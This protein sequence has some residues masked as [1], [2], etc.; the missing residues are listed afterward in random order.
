MVG[1]REPSRLGY[2]PSW[3]GLAFE[4]GVRMATRA[5]RTGRWLIAVALVAAAGGF[6]A[7]AQFRGDSNDPWEVEVVAEFPH[8]PAAFTQG[9][10]ISGG[11]LYESTGRYGASSIRRVDIETGQIERLGALNARLFGEGLTIRGDRA[12]QLTW[13]SG[14]GIVYDVDTFEILETFRYAGEGWGLTH[15]GTH[16]ILSDGTAVLRFI[17]PENYEQAKRLTVR[18]GDLE[19]TRLNEL[20]YIRGEIWANVWY[21]D[22]IARISPA[23]GRVLGWIDLTDIY[24]S[25]QRGSRDEVL[26]GIA[27]DA[28]TQ[29]LFV[30]GKNWPTLY[31]I[32]IVE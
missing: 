17:D 16:L 11:N 22:R 3:P 29:R 30:T 20:E 2:D 23:D 31:E 27:F 32:R 9:L 8:D 1:A 21:E 28:A 13:Q 19:L 12:Y 14:L 24:P 25:W 4:Y 5:R 26:N 6:A 7:W 10:V 15:D 18:D